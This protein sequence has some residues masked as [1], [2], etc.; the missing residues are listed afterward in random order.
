MPRVR[1]DLLYTGTATEPKAERDAAEARFRA[2]AAQAGA[3][4][5]APAP[6]VRAEAEGDV[7]AQFLVLLTEAGIPYAIE[8][9]ETR[10]DLDEM[11]A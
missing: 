11:P 5:I 10:A 6:Q 9:Q 4:V 1:F 7:L 2:L 8:E 3:R